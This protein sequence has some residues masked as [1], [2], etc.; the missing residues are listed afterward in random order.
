MPRGSNYKP[1]TP[2][3]NTYEATNDRNMQNAYAILNR[4]E[5]RITE[6]ESQVSNLIIYINTILEDKLK[7]F[8]L[9]MIDGK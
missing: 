1:E 3:E 6:L 8:S 2:R 9:M 4:H 5:D 7:N